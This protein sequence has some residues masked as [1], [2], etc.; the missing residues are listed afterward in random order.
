VL[1]S[2]GLPMRASQ[3]CSH[4]SKMQ[5][6]NEQQSQRHHEESGCKQLLFLI[7]H[8]FFHCSIVNTVDDPTIQ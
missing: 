4:T 1:W 7:G 6:Q 5:T 8:S 3:V 2:S